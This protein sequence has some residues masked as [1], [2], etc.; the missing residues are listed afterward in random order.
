VCADLNRNVFDPTLSDA[1]LVGFNQ[2]MVP[3]MAAIGW[4]FPPASAQG[5]RDA[6]ASATPPEAIYISDRATSLTVPGPAG[7]VTLRVVAP[8][9]PPQAIYL[10]CHGGGWT[11]GG[12]AMND[13]ALER[14]ADGADVT[15]VSID[16]RLAPEF[17]YPAGLDD[18]EAA[19]EWVLDHGAEQ[20][21][22]GRVIIGGESAGANL[23]LC[24]LLRVNARRP[25][26]IVASNLL[27]GNYDLTMTPSQRMAPDRMITTDSLA[28]FY[29]QYVPDTEL[30]G[31]PD[32]SPL[33]ADLSGL[34][35]TLVSV[36]NE[37][38]LVDDSMFLASRMLLAGVECELYV[39][40]GG[41]HAFDNAPVESAR[42]AVA[43][44]DGF[45]AQHAA[46]SA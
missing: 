27:Y 45:I 41:E 31:H 19:A 46:G 36:G 2:L 14:I 26:A 28:W 39:V 1:E 20:L 11:I 40:P 38:S 8:P 13:A 10:H 7:E 29:D 5:L 23:A 15:V 22:S 24:T 9:G 35:P 34:P 43:R 42:A 44:I 4:T 16:Y 37:D 3:G 33:Y 30:R 25:G 32:V 17:P 21:G 6:L 18:C 12:A